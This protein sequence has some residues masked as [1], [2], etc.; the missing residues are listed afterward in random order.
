MD[1]MYKCIMS[2]LVDHSD[3]YK[4]TLLEHLETINVNGIIVCTMFIYTGLYG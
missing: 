3:E 1:Y 2:C 4:I